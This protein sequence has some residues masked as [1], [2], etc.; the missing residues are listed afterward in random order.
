MIKGYTA[1]GEEL[2]INTHKSEYLKFPGD[3][4]SCHNLEPYLHGVAGTQGK[5][6]GF[7]LEVKRD[8]ALVN[9]DLDAVKDEYLVPVSWW[10]M[11]NKGMVQE[12]DGSWILKDHEDDNEL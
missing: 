3:L 4:K 9:K 5:R 7:H 11:H 8:I 12:D 6:G 2:V 1:V 10:C